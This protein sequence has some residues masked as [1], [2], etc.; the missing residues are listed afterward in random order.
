MNRPNI[1]SQAFWDI[2]FDK[3]DFDKKANFVITRVFEYGSLS[4][5]RF[6]WQFYGKDKIKDSIINAHFLKSSAI[7]KASLLLE[8]PKESIKC[9]NTRP[10]HLPF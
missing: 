4:D 2:D 3:I 6:L 9:Y 8:I 7:S 1:S 10:S 5:L